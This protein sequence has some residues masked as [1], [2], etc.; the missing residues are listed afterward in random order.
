MGDGRREKQETGGRRTETGKIKNGGRR[1]ETGDGKN[2]RRET[3]KRRM[4]TGDRGTFLVDI[5]CLSIYS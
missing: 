1:R 4:E 2:R 3:G 5:D